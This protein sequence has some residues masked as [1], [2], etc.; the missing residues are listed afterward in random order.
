ME[1]QFLSSL[2]SAFEGATTDTAAVPNML[3]YLPEGLSAG[4][5][6]TLWAGKF[7]NWA[8]INAGGGVVVEVNATSFR[9]QGN[10][11][12]PVEER[13]DLELKILGASEAMIIEHTRGTTIP[14]QL[15]SNPS[16]LF[17]SYT[18]E[19]GR[20]SVTEQYR[21]GHEVRFWNKNL[22]HVGDAS[23]HLAFH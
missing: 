10:T 5:R 8:P 2:A 20:T 19:P 21:T 6:F 4:T 9:I 17:Y 3:D 13:F 23:A 16:N 12:W 7:Y 22:P 14:A 15:R 18:S 11:N 1:T